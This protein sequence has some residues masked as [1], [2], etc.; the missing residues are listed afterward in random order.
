MFDGILTDGFLFANDYFFFVF[1]TISIENRVL[2]SIMVF[3][4]NCMLTDWI[5]Y[6]EVSVIDFTYL[7]VEL[8]IESVESDYKDSEHQWV[9]VV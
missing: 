9:W 7:H 5:E 4:N 8:G 6:L 1:K 3:L 2:F